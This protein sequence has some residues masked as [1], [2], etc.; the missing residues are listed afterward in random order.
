[1]SVGA[2]WCPRVPM[3]VCGCLSV[4]TGVCGYVRV[5]NSV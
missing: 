4:P 1:M 3:D 2:D 5:T